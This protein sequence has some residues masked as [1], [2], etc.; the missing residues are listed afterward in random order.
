M[1]AEGLQL[2]GGDWTERKLDALGQYLLAYAKALSKTNFKRVY[3][4]AFAGTGYREQRTSP[5]AAQL[6][7]FE[8]ELKELTA[9]E[10]QRFLDGSAKIALKVQPPFHRFVFIEFD[11]DKVRELEKLKTEF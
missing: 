8:D 9:P 11:E 1:A 2:F 4:D 6:S 7:I 5:I 3:I 10:S